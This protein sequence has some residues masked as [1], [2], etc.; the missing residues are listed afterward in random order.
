MKH[1]FPLILKLMLSCELTEFKGN[2][3]KS[4]QK[5]CIVYYFEGVI[6]SIY[7]LILTLNQC[8]PRTFFLNR[9]TTE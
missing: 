8:S 6:L 1:K 2:D 5:Q 7:Y 9:K 3:K 4:K